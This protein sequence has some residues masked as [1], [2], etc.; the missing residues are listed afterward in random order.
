MFFPHVN[1]PGTR[2]KKKCFVKAQRSAFR[3]V[4]AQRTFMHWVFA[5]PAI[6]LLCVVVLFP[7]CSSTWSPG[8]GAAAGLLEIAVSPRISLPADRTFP[9]VWVEDTLETC[10]SEGGGCQLGSEGLAAGGDLY[11]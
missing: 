10:G 7:K 3:G 4:A 6:R 2:E 9:G 1:K 8:A 11:T 5:L